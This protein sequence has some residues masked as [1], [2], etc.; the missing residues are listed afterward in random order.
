[1]RLACNTPASLWDE[2]CATAAYL[3]TLTAATANNGKTP[4]ELWFGRKPSLS[5]LKEIGCRAFA[6][7]TPALS[8]VYQ[9]SFPCIL[10][11]YAPHSKAY[12]LWDPSSSHVFNSYH[13]SF[14]EHL[15]SES[16]PLSP[17]TVLGTSS[18][19][20]APSW[21]TS[22][23]E[24]A[25]TN[26]AQPHPPFS[27]LPTVPDSSIP[28]YDPT[29]DSHTIPTHV[30]RPNTITNPNDPNTVTMNNTA[31]NTVTT[32]NTVNT[33]PNNTRNT[34]INTINTVPP[35]A[36]N[37]DADTIP[38]LPPL[39]PLSPLSPSPPPIPPPRR[40]SRVP[41]PS[42]RLT[43]NDGSR[44]GPRL[45]AAISEARTS[46]VCRQE[47]RAQ[48]SIT[49]QTDHAFAILSEYS[50]VRDTHDLFHADLCFD[51]NSLSINRE[52]NPYCNC[53]AYT[54]P[55]NSFGC[56]VV[57]ATDNERCFFA[58]GVTQQ[59]CAI[60][61]NARRQKIKFSRYVLR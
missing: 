34:V 36:T 23:P 59:Y 26:T 35:I 3:T 60:M 22:G 32:N 56:W 17:G 55:Y 24:P 58:Y 43:T 20:S 15:D 61:P 16:S 51:N 46:R 5:H 38:P 25:H 27:T 19:P 7:H 50:E 8:K 40:T 49:P 54:Y 57:D 42:T 14:T 11:G 41:V 28:L 45:A 53:S 13:I 52:N 30:I 2:F 21:D 37:T 4:Y 48:R 1:M 29:L 31:N 33:N 39:S 6:L 47:E 10:I 18:P 12:R 9:R 44:H